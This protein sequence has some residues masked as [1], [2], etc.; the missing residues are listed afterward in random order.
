[1]I[2][3]IFINKES[4]TLFFNNLRKEDYL[5][6]L[7]VFKQ[8]PKDELI[9]LILNLDEVYF[10]A[11]EKNY[12]LAI[13]GLV[14]ENNNKG[15][16]WL[17]FAKGFENYRYEIFKYIKNKLVIYKNKYD[18][19]YNFVFKSNY[20]ILKWLKKQG[21]E[22]VEIEIPQYKLFYYKRR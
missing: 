7:D 17:L 3:E 13:G 16:V 8:N 4:L 14:K 1:M 10:L 18:I 19:L 9:S 6:V 21:F 2:K 20:G 5:E 12:P 15:K 22:I 11:N